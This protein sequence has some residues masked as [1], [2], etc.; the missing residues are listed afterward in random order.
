M[1]GKIFTAASTLMGLMIGLGLGIAIAKF[2]GENPAHVLRVIAHSAF[3]SRYDLGLTLFYATPLIFCGLSVAIAFQAGLFNIGAEGQLQLGALAAASVGVLLPKVPGILAPCLA[4]MAATI[5][6]A[7]WAWIPGWL[8]VRRG[9]HEVITTIML[10]FVAAS[11]ISWILRTYLQNPNAQNPETGD[12][13]RAYFL[14]PH[15][16]ISH[17]FGNAPVGIAFPVAIA[18]AGLLWFLLEKTSFGFELRASGENEDAAKGSGIAVGRTRILAMMIAGALA[19]WVALPEVMGN[20]GRF[21][22]GFSSDYGFIGIAVAL[23][24]RN[25]PILVIFSGV[26]FGALHKGAGDLD[27]ETDHVTHDLSL[28][29]Q[30]LVILAVS[31]SHLFPVWWNARKKASHGA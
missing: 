18:M 25:N 15:D 27:I 13:G 29:I 7:F 19:A 3:G 4:L 8:R 6:G 23:L 21:R 22:D 24:A 11:F 31:L 12:I 17:L 26:L 2:A 30:A 16:P 1:P 28:I 5:V 14:H 9:S 20:A 10:N